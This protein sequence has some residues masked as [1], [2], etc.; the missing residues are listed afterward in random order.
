MDKQLTQKMENL[1]TRIEREDKRASSSFIFSMVCRILIT[2]LLVC[3]LTYIGTT[4]SKLASPANVAVVLN[5]K[6]LDSIP[7]MHAQLNQD[8]PKHAK[9]LAQS[10]VQLL[11]KAIPM[12]GDMLE[13]QIE[14]RFDQLMEHY[15]VQRE[16]AFENIC[17]RVIDKI[18]KHKDLAT[19]VTLAQV[20]AVQLAD[21]CDREAKNIINNAFFSEIE[22][23]QCEHALI[24]AEF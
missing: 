1:L 7:N 5:Q 12:V 10:S 9:K 8:L 24:L 13:K 16:Q 22:K 14:T 11:H 17:S 23:L 15:K 3:S 18:K 19:D 2:L 4:F 21:E 20:L 6:V